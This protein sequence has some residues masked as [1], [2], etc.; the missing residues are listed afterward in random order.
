MKYIKYFENTTEE[1]SKTIAFG[2]TP[3]EAKMKATAN[4]YN[5]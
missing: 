1:A 4:K 3:E 5:L 2:K